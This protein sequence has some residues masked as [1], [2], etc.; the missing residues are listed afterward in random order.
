M[1]EE[2]WN[3]D[4]EDKLIEHWQESPCLYDVSSKL[5][6]NRLQKRKSLEEIASKLNMTSKQLYSY[7]F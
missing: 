6:S 4:L 1:A 2:D 7:A 5:Y 3:T